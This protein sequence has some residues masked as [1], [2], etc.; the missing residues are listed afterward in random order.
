MMGTNKLDE[1]STKTL[2][3]RKKIGLILV[4]FNYGIAFFNL[5]LLG[6]KYGLEMFQTSSSNIVP[7]VFIPSLMGMIIS[8]YKK[9][10]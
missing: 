2:K 5:G 8:I 3:R 6:Y 9:N 1:L 10:L 7:M 4:W